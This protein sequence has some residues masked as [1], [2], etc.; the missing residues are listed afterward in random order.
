[1]KT[2][3]GGLHKKCLQN[4][5]ALSPE[6]RGEGKGEI[7][8]RGQKSPPVQS[9]LYHSNH[10]SNVQD[11]TSITLPESILALMSGTPLEVSLPL[12]PFTFMISFSF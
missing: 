5:P 7:S 12:P 4:A 2:R 1:M 3:E 8:S 11:G 6:I 10:F 9:L